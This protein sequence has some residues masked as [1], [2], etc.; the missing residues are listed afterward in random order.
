VRLLRGEEA[1]ADAQVAG[2]GEEGA[3]CYG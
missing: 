1:Q 3:H 2:G